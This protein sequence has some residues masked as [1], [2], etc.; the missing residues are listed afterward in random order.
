MKKVVILGTAHLATTPGKASPDGKFREAD[1][2]RDLVNSIKAKLEALGY[3]VFIDHADLQPTADLLR[4]S[5]NTQQQ[6]ELN[7]RCKRVNEIC[8][9]YG[10]ENCVYVSIHVNGAGDGAKWMTAGGWCAYTTKGQTKAD[11]LATCLYAAARNNLTEYVK[12]LNAGK[13]L[14]KYGKNQVAYRTDTA[15]GDDDLESD[16]YVLKHT[17][18]PAV[19]TENLFQDNA[20]DV[21]FLTSNLGRHALERLH[22]EGILA[23]FNQQKK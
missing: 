8:N 10:T 9:M 19:L 21:A 20:E 2:S 4:C 15:D 3:L 7:Y 23:Y 13:L 14:G 12:Y 6:K 11:F 5:G 22:V 1:Y 16:F 18:C 17:K